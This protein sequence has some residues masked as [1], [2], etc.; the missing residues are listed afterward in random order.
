MAVD[1][2][3]VSAVIRYAAPMRFLALLLL[4]GA[5]A[6]AADYD[7]LLRGGRV[8]DGTGNPAFFSDIAV[9]DGRIVRVGKIN[10]TAR[11]EVDATGK[12]VCPG[13]IDVHTHAEEI[14]ELP[15]AENFVR[16]GVTTIVLGNCGSSVL[17]VGE[18][19]TRLESTNP[20]VNVATLIGHGSVRS[21]IMG[22]S[23]MRP[24]TKEELTRMKELVEQAM[25]DG[26]VGLSTGLIYLPGTFAKTEEIIELAKVAAAHDG[27]YA[28]HMRSEG[29]EIFD[30]LNELFRI[31]RE[32]GIR[33]EVSH[34]KLSGKQNWGHPEQVIAALEQARREGL[35]VTQDQYAYTASS[36]GISQLVPEHAREG[37]KFKERLADPNEKMKIVAEMKEK[38][39][40]GQRADYAYATIAEYKADP[41][42]NG[43]NIVEAIRKKRG[44]G[45]LDDQ[46]DLILE[47]Q[48]NG[49]ASGVFHGISE[50]DLRAFLQH[51]N[52]MIASDS[53]IRRWREGVPHPRGYGNNARVLGR[54]VRELKVL[55][56]EDAIRRMT[57]LPAS[58]FRLQNRGRLSEGHWADIVVFDPETVQDNATFAEPHQYAAGF[59]H[60]FVNGI[61]VVSN[62]HHTGERPGH[63]L[64]HQQ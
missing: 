55:R 58:T 48:K 57:S 14:N 44:S 9:K 27:I 6:T 11:R 8:V 35:D 49:G 3:R 45:S 64:R 20:S 2:N 34:I 5:C 38:L 23:F 60:V 37:G 31:A 22:G 25:K 19:F 43:L 59:A 61:E 13:F 1:S 30:A 40:K 12:I 28:S 46:I 33:A 54:Y 63:A 21:K 42:L 51:P 50:N 10:G 7:L 18:F 29:E 56:L 53:G 24:P 15:L 16:M 39:R 62:D 41:S 26:A 36:T 32:A 52:T 47:I 4:C 17:N